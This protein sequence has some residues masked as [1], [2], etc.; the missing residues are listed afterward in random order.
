MPAIPQQG[1]EAEDDSGK[2]LSVL[3]Y[4][5]ASVLVTAYLVVLFL[6]WFDVGASDRDWARRLQLLSAL[7]ALAA[8]GAGAL[9]GTTVQR[10]ATRKEARR[11]DGERL[12]ADDNQAA[13]EGGRA[14][15]KA[16]RAKLQAASDGGRY[17]TRGL[18]EAAQPV[19][20]ELS[21]LAGLADQYGL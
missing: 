13:A 12:R 2:R 10:R 16:T 1:S 5:V 18:G 11:A 20:S 9:L 3:A 6:Q 15:A 8:A 7:E 19:A 17:E 21:E 14:M 4:L